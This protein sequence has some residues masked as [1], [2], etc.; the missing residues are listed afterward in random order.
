M[1]T[2]LFLFTLTIFVKQYFDKKSARMYCFYRLW[3]KKKNSILN[4]EFFKKE[5]VFLDRGIKDSLKHR[6]LRVK[7]L[8]F[9]WR[10]LTKEEKKL[11]LVHVK[12]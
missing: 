1:L 2:Y 3:L 6:Y 4:D 7:R 8:S 5:L 10:N 9:L 11:F 12:K